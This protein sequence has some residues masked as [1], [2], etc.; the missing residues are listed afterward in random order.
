[1]ERFA[2]TVPLQTLNFYVEKVEMIRILNFL[3]VL[4]AYICLTGC[5][6][7]SI[8]SPQSILKLTSSQPDAL[9]TKVVSQEQNVFN[10]SGKANF[11]WSVLNK[12]GVNLRKW[13]ASYRIWNNEPVPL[14]DRVED[15][16]V[17]TEGGATGEANLDVFHD[18][19][20]AFMKAHEYPFP[21]STI[22][23]GNAYVVSSV[24]PMFADVTLF[25]EDE[26]GYKQTLTGVVKMEDK[27]P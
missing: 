15:I 12:I 23:D 5:G 13:S 24:S 18:M 11:K 14:L 27:V 2:S 21:T 4:L 25:F 10:A 6:N 26:N 20:V 9:Y 3:L 1:M 22:K 7:S 19:A 8:F 17:Y 16:L